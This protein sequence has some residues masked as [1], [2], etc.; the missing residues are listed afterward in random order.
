MRRCSS[1]DRRTDLGSSSR[2]GRRTTSRPNPM[3]DSSRPS[4]SSLGS[5]RPESIWLMLGWR[6]PLSRESSDWVVPVSL[7]TLPRMSRRS[8][9]KSV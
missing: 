4:I 1:H 9:T 5:T 6:T 3:H 8:L 2:T 7:I